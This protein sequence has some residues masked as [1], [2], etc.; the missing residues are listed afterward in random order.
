MKFGLKM[1]LAAVAMLVAIGA[2]AQEQIRDFGPQWGK[3]A[4]P[5]Q[6]MENVKIYNFYKDAMTARD[7]EQAVPF[8]QHLLRE[9]P[10]GT[11]NIY[12]YGTT[13]YKNKI[14]RAKSLAEKKIYVDSLML[15]YDMRIEHF[16]NLP[17]KGTPYLLKLKARDY[18]IYNPSDREGIRAMFRQALD[19]GGSDFDP[20]FLNIYFQ[21]LVNDY[22]V[23]LVG[24]DE[25][26]N[27]YERISEMLDAHVSPESDEARKTLDALL[28]SSGAADCANLEKLFAARLEAAPDDAELLGKAFRF[29]SRENCDSPFF[30]EV[31]ERYFA[32]DPS[33]NTAMMLAKAF[34][35]KGNSERAMNYLREALNKEA[36][37]VTKAAL[38]V[39]IA[40]MEIHAKNPREAA[41]FAKQ[42]LSIDPQNGYAYIIL[43]QAYAAGASGCTGF[44][45]QSV[46][47]LAY[48]TALQART[49]VVSNPT[50]L[51]S[52]EQMLAAYR[53]NFPS[54]EEC[55]FRSLNEGD[56]YAV[57]CGWVSGSTTVR[58]GK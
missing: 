55:F 31:G 14:A 38:S 37:P 26:L 36:D 16:G 20:D 22:G 1:L 49:L 53:A 13:I 39:Q 43:A 11:Q 44:D 54:R 56:A 40:G 25:L 5:Q 4:T 58:P 19:A 32:A 8:L 2:T 35:K 10:K 21:E 57:H 28:I 17:D 9:S 29:M 30:F 47:W 42:A 6:R 12:I 52:V 34:E 3:D 51:A 27:E 41:N 23:D 50:E 48:D 7:Y 46:Y 18:L 45:A 33:S 24:A 15:L